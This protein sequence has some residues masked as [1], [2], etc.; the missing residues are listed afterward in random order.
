MKSILII[1]DSCEYRTILA[2]VL[3][4]NGYEVVTADCPD[5][6]YS[7]LIDQKFDLVISDLHMPFSFGANRHEFV[8]SAEVGLR[9]IKELSADM[10]GTRFLALSSMAQSDLNRLSQFVYP[11]PVFNKPSGTREILE[12]VQHVLSGSESAP[13]H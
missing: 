6:A 10:P 7:S 2:D 9:T 13:L 4:L 12:I 11:V 8:E 3:E 5:S 1:D